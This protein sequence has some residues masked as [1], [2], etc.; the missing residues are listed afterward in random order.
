[1]KPNHSPA[2]TITQQDVGRLSAMVSLYGEAEDA[3]TSAL[4]EELDRANVVAQ[5]AVSPNVVTMNSRVVC[6]DD[7][8]AAREV[9]VVYP[10]HS[11]TAAGKISVLAPL[12]R[13]LLGAA[14]GDTIEVTGRGRA[15]TWAIASIEYQ[16]ES[17]GHF[18]L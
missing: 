13:A 14:V 5:G 2:I 17:S 11:N 7:G 15:R 3:A 18:E 9:Q 12:G 4:Q 16:P 6:H 8:G 1:M 10:W